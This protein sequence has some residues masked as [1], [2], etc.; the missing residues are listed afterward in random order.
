MSV[1]VVDGIKDIVLHNGIVR[2]DCLT[3]GPGGEQRASGSILIPGN[4]TG[5]ILQA[6]VNAMQELDR[7]IR[8]QAAEQAKAA[9]PADAD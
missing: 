8:E 3:A 1:V 5:P 2:I 4:V 6:I 9:A 7:R